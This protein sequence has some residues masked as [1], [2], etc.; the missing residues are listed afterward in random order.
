MYLIA[1]LVSVHEKVDVWTGPKRSEE[2]IFNESQ[3]GNN[4]RS[5]TIIIEKPIDLSQGQ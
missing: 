1:T 4:D 5:E 3:R 2:W